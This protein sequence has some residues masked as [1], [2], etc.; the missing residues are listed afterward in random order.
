MS[1][2]GE[3]PSPPNPTRVYPTAM[4]PSRPPLARGEPRL[5]A[6]GVERAEPPAG[7]RRPPGVLEPRRRAGRRSGPATRA[8]PGEPVVPR[9]RHLLHGDRGARAPSADPR[10]DV[11]A[12]RRAAATTPSRRA[13]PGRCS[14]KRATLASERER[15]SA[16]HAP[17]SDASNPSPSTPALVPCVQARRAPRA[18]R[19]ARTSHSADAARGRVRRRRPRRAPPRARRAGAGPATTPTRRGGRAPVHDRRRRAGAARRARRR[20]RRETPAQR[21]DASRRAPGPA[22]GRTGRARTA[23]R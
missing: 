8:L 21:R 12:S 13:S 17:P 4:R 3:S 7:E 2:A 9:A 14:A 16:R 23:P 18:R 11:R 6:N 5:R 22:A 19:P 20:A 15:G 1:A 10:R